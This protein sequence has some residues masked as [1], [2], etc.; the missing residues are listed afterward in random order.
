MTD[1]PKE[2]PSENNK[3][4]PW[5]DILKKMMPEKLSYLFDTLVKAVRNKRWDIVLFVITI[6]CIV[7][8]VWCYP[9]RNLPFF[10]HGLFGLS[11]LAVLA[12]LCLVWHFIH[13]LRSRRTGMIAQSEN[14]VT[15][16]GLQSLS[17][18]LI[19][20]RNTAAIFPDEI[21]RKL[22]LECE[23]EHQKE[24]LT[25]I[26]VQ[27]SALITLM[28]KPGS[29]KT[30]L[31]QSGVKESLA[32][33]QIPYA[34]WEATPT[35]TVHEFIDSVKSQTRLKLEND[36]NSILAI[37][38]R[39][40]IAIDQFELLHNNALHK[41]FFDLML[42]LCRVPGPCK[43]QLIAAFRNEYR[44][45]WLAFE[46]TLRPQTPIDG[47]EIK[48]FNAVKSQNIMATLLK[49]TGY[50]VEHEVVRSYVRKVADD[51][52]VSPVAIGIGLRIMSQW[53][54][55]SKHNKITFMSFD[56]AGSTGGIF[57]SYVWSWFEEHIPHNDWPT[58][59]RALLSELTTSKNRIKLSGA[60]AETI[61]TTA[62]L[63]IQKA[64]SYLATLASS[65]ARILESMDHGGVKHY[66]FANAHLI[67]A[68]AG[69]Y[70][71]KPSEDVSIQNTFDASYAE[72]KRDPNIQQERGKQDQ[73]LL[74]DKDLKALLTNRARII[75]G[76]E[77]YG[78]AEYLTECLLARSERRRRMAA[79]SLFAGVVLLISIG[80][81]CHWLE[82]RRMHG[83]LR[84]WRLPADLLERQYQLEALSIDR[85]EMKNLKWLRSPRL[86]E[87]KIDKFGGSN[88]DGIENLTGIQRL[89]IH[90][91]KSDLEEELSERKRGVIRRSSVW[92]RDK[93]DLLKINQLKE[94]K[95]LDLDLEGSKPTV[96][97]SL[98]GLHELQK[99]A[100]D[101][102][103]SEIRKIPLLN[104]RLHHLELILDQSKVDDLSGLANIDELESLTLDVNEFSL[105]NLSTILKSLHLASRFH[106]ELIIN[107]SPLYHVPDLSGIQGI[108]GLTL[109]L[110]KTKP[111]DLESLKN[112]KGAEELGLFLSNA[113]SGGLD[114]LSAIN[115]LK[116][117]KLHLGNPE[118]RDL[119]E[120][121]AHMESVVLELNGSYV[122]H[123]PSFGNNELQDLS[124]SVAFSHVGELDAIFK[125]VSLRTLTLNVS[126]AGSW[127]LKPLSCLR[128]LRDATLHLTWSKTGQIKG[129][130]Q[131]PNMTHLT[132]H[133]EGSGMQDLQ[134]LEDFKNVQELTLDLKE[135]DLARFPDL[136]KMSNLHHLTL[137]LE[138]SQMKDLSTISLLSGLQSLELDVADTT[139]VQLPDVTKLKQL[140]NLRLNL[141]HSS[142][143]DLNQIRGLSALEE[144]TLDSS[145]SRFQSLDGLPPQ[146]KKLN[147]VQ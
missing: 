110:E 132:L 144:L 71:K 38:G 105:H 92:C 62:K 10:R 130:A 33:E 83:Q 36:V 28:G 44:P 52:G 146:V 20:D 54:S 112:I 104:H 31:L 75:V 126:S 114:V 97:S 65:K 109:H 72:W 95:E 94:L 113:Y 129:L 58:L 4:E 27:K 87:L 40:I 88:L 101:L 67:S 53:A 107:I 56:N 134:F 68:I 17:N 32:Q 117:I 135:T 66:R 118:M 137:N 6:M 12:V 139:V 127:D 1:S 125:A 80:T 13:R 22:E 103:L 5:T 96:L 77:R 35:K 147:F 39:L 145:N 84:S 47:V 55:A 142:I 82:A 143:S 108:R 89:E 102:K 138:S 70:P 25:L 74:R 16:S 7:A 123:L 115:G 122:Q 111:E 73:F 78:K 21:F 3:K 45:E 18:P 106:L 121:F 119:P 69:L 99:L 19:A 85:K 30:S 81:V 14:R 136:S 131:L 48:P 59:K 26:R 37:P 63:E 57:S 86:I 100:L 46:T 51:E 41:P 49:E 128:E 124:I 2:A 15:V 34:Y 140:T 133:L 116:R 23:L 50:D 61:A 120:A 60:T 64:E 9:H 42:T 91:D 11:V 79:G 24:L 141:S 98:E 29:G 93:P 76:R 43:I 8:A 90:C